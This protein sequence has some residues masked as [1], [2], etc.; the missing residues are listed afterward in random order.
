MC[1]DIVADVLRDRSVR[2]SLE[3]AFQPDEND[4]RRLV[5]LLD[6]ADPGAILEF[7]SGW[8][9]VVIARWL[10][11][12]PGAFLETLEADPSFYV[13]TQRALTL[14][15]GLERFV[16]GN[17]KVLQLRTKEWEPN[18]RYRVLFSPVA[19]GQQADG[20]AFLYQC[21]T[22]PDF[23]YLDGPALWGRRIIT[24]NAMT[25]VDT[26]RPMVFLIDGRL[27]CAS[28][29]W[30]FYRLHLRL[31]YEWLFCCSAGCSLVYHEE[32]AHVGEWF[33]RTHECERPKRE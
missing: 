33:E 23:V 19:I 11:D 30:Q 2:R 31:P 17:S 15:R 9:T 14:A 4:L 20:V 12:H 21:L 22:A 3:P 1:T 28:R 16:D 8:S 13:N 10:M 27:A 26:T 25:C 7:G 5:I 32:F 6:L 18:E 24:E 29:L